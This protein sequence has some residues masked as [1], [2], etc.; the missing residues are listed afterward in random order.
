MTH[1]HHS[2]NGSTHPE[3]S[4][5]VLLTAAVVL[6]LGAAACSEGNVPFYTAPT[7]VPSSIAGLDNAVS[8][9]FAAS[10]NDLGAFQ[11]IEFNTVAG[12]ARDGA[13][14]TNTEPRTVTYPL[15]VLVI[16]NTSGTVWAQE[17]QNITQAQQIIAALP[18]ISTLL[19]APQTA[20]VT[21][22]FFVLAKP[23]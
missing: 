12:Y 22:V 10:R 19:T 8:G 6:A 3:A 23:F 1:I 18:A 17:Y 5:R 11:G 13:V 15:G 14:F 4:G 16:P 2:S 21:G 7:S 9:L 20:S